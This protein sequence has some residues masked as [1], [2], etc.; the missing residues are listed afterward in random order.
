M[1]LRKKHTALLAQWVFTVEM[2][3]FL[4]ASLYVTIALILGVDIWLINAK[5]RDLLQMYKHTFW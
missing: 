3:P 1:D 2:D 5:E 4:K